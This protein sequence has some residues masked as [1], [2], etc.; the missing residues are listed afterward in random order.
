M[1]S[2]KDL[3]KDKEKYKETLIAKNKY[4]SKEFQD[5][6]YR[7]AMKLGEEKNVSLYIRLAKE[8]P[9]AWLEQALS[10]AVDYPNAKNKARLFMWKLKQLETEYFDAK[11]KKAEMSDKAA[12]SKA[13]KQKKSSKA[14]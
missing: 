13:P 5:Y 10:F 11:D 14:K 6:G 12:E 4:V 9:R 2:F 1:E 3:L 8:K 7:L